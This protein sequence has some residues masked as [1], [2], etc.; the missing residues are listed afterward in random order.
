MDVKI[1]TDLSLSLKSLDPFSHSGFFSLV[2][3]SCMRLKDFALFLI[4]G[5][6]KP[7][8]TM[9]YDVNWSFVDS[10]QEVGRLPVDCWLPDLCWCDCFKLA[11]DIEFCLF[12]FPP[13]SFE[14]SMRFPCF[15]LLMW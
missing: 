14:M 2:R 8:F 7:S 12:F 5:E 4:L 15:R 13:V 6:S 1:K 3:T 10:F 9:E 11:K